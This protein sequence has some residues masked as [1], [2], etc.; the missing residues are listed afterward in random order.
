[1]IDHFFLFLIRHLYIFYFF[2]LNNPATPDIYPL[3]LPAPLPISPAWTPASGQH[4]NVRMV[5]LGG[6]DHRRSAAVRDAILEGLR[7]GELAARDVD[8]RPGVYLV[9]G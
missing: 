7:V 2:F 1:M 5:F 9:G 3:P 8:R 6:G 4:D